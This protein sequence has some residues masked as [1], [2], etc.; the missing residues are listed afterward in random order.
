MYGMKHSRA[1]LVDVLLV[2]VTAPLWALIIYEM[3]L[4]EGWIGITNSYLVGL[5]ILCVLTVAVFWLLRTRR[6]AW[7]LSALASGFIVF[8]VLLVT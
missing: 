4:R 5:P 6:H 7:S 2:L 8:A 3:R 1:L